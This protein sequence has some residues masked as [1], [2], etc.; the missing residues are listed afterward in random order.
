L[1]TILAFKPSSSAV[2]TI[3][4]ERIDGPK[5]A[6]QTVKSRNLLIVA[7]RLLPRLDELNTNKSSFDADSLALAAHIFVRQ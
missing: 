2:L 6:N 5:S 4:R 1:T 3:E 7:Q